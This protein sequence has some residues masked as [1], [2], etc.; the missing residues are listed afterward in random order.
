[1]QD[2]TKKKKPH[3][4]KRTNETVGNICPYCEGIREFSSKWYVEQH[5]S[6]SHQDKRRRMI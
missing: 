3:K 5:I 6:D 4:P 1:M 2:E